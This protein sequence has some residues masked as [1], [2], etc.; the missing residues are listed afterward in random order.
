VEKRYAL[1]HEV[2]ARFQEAGILEDLVLVGS[3]CIYF[4]RDYFADISY[5]TRIRTRDIDFLVPTPAKSKRTIDIAKLLSD[6]GFIVT[7]SPSGFMRLEHPELIVEFLVAERGR[8]IDKPYPLPRFGL[9]AQALRF[10]DFLAQNTITVD[11]DS[12]RLKMPHPVAFGLHKL[13]VT[14]RRKVDEKAIKEK[15]EALH[16]LR[17]LILKGESRIVREMYL[18]M[19]V[20]WRKKV[21]VAL[22]K[23]T[24]KDILELLG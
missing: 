18:Q 16:V 4:Y 21:L 3:W 11:I 15:E 8:G 1:C 10:L 7:F 22:D 13:I 19:P 24:E 20:P 5:S 2:L 6:R 17:A 9:N 23:E 14:K 12:L